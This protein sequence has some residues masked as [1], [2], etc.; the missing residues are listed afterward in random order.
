MPAMYMSN[1]DSEHN[2]ITSEPKKLQSLSILEIH[3]RVHV[4]GFVDWHFCLAP[5]NM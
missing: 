4:T 2:S 5:R 1:L 3:F